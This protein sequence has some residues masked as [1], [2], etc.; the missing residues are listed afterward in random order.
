M[1]VQGITKN[2][3]YFPW[4]KELLDSAKDKAEHA[5]VSMP[6]LS[7]ISERIHPSLPWLF[8]QHYI[9]NNNCLCAPP[10]GL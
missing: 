1:N 3:S 10:V 4:A 7:V 8:D 9:M 5:L 2:C 6:V